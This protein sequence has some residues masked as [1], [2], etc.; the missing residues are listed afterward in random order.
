MVTKEENERMTLVAPGT[1]G[2]EML[3]R[4]WWPIA[5]S[6]EIKGPRPKLVRLLGEDFVLFRD[7]AGALGLIEPHC[8]HRR[9]HLKHGR[10]EQNGIRCCYHGWVFDTKG[11]CLEQ[12]CEDPVRN[13]KDRIRMKVYPVQDAAGLVFAYIGP[14]P[15]PLLPR[16]D[17]LVHDEGIRYVWGFRDHCNWLQDAEQACD[18]VHLGWLHAGPY[19]IYANKKMKF[20]INRRPWGIDYAFEVPGVPD[21]NVGNVVFP[22]HNRFA[23]GRAEQALGTRQNMLF[24]TPV[25]DTTT[26]NFFIT[27][28]I[29][30]D[31]QK[32]TKTETPPEQAHRGP[33]IPTERGIYPPGDEAWWGVESMMQDRM[34]LESQ[35]LIHDRTLENLGGSDAGIAIWRTLVRD[36]IDAVAAGK[37]P[38]GVIRDPARNKVV[39]FGTKMHTYAPPLR[40][41]P[42]NAAA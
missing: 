8:A 23:S 29:T 14:Q 37:D 39:E 3:R 5:F 21:Q 10:V 27:L 25:D 13:S 17:M 42:E 4:Y 12:P 24:R 1:P 15:A 32:V 19:P 36:S 26:D 31:A 7:G 16:Y 28:Y 20:E 30:G 40:P 41:L 22:C 9:A 35:G 6:A 33:W 34:C 18:P 11:H 38:F 2:G